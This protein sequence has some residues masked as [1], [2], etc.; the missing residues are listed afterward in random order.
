MTSCQ[1]RIRL[2]W[3]LRKGSAMIFKSPPFWAPRLPLFLLLILSFSLSPDSKAEEIPETPES[4]LELPPLVLG[5]GEQRMLK[6]PGL[7]KYSLGS[8]VIRVLPVPKSLKNLALRAAQEQLLIKGIEAGMGDL[9][10]WKKDGKSEH[11]LIRVEKVSSDDLKP[12]LERALSHL[13]ETE[14]IMTGKGV[15]LKGPVRVASELAR[16]QAIARDFPGIVHDETLPDESLLKAAQLKLSEWLKFSHYSDRLRIEKIDDTIWVR[17]NLENPAEQASVERKI[18]SLFPSVELEIQSLPDHA[19]TVH[20]RVYLLELRKS[21]F[22]NLG[23][24]WPAV[25]EGAFQ[26]TTSAIND[27]LKLDLALEALEGKGSARVL[28]KPELVVRAPGEAELFSGGELPIHMQS[29]FFSNVSWKSYGL[30]LK[31]KVTHTTQERVRLDIFTEVSH[32]DPSISSDDKIPGI[33]ANRMKTQVDALYGTP[34]LLSGLLQEGTREQAKG[35]PLLRQIPILGSLFGSADYLN[36]KSELV[37]I[38][39]PSLSPPAPPMEKVARLLPKGT[40]PPPR[41]W[42]SPEKERKLTQ[43][44][45]YPWNAL[46]NALGNALE[47]NFPE[48]E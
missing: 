24:S 8:P 2:A 3:G 44:S 43:S 28:S 18:H 40:I 22:R 32:L 27:F 46:G 48:S 6:I 15:I 33:Q 25:Q 11:R 19:P 37:A 17:G 1:F 35:L 29:H 16:I 7:A 47:N 14:V 4:W 23:L 5:K 45:D 41:N 31:L 10:V 9:W 39:L 13:E 36:E 38:L 42:I 30:T 34:L 12:A 20:F 26:V 21:A